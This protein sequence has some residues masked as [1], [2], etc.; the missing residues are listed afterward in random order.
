MPNPAIMAPAA[1]ASGA[2]GAAAA[3]AIAG[4]AQAGQQIAS[5]TAAAN[6]YGAAAGGLSEA[7]KAALI[8]GGLQAGAGVAQGIASG[9]LT[10]DPA[11]PQQ[12]KM[13]IPGGN[14]GGVGARPAGQP[15]FAGRQEMNPQVRSSLANQILQ[16]RGAYR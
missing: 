9:L 13:A 6:A 15:L 8:S 12:Q 1:G 4:A 14:P 7:T 5:A 2:K 11:K 16:Q 3:P 10:K